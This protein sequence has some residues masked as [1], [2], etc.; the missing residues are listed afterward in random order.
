MS[1]PPP[2]PAVTTAA[3]DEPPAVKTPQPAEAVN[4]T[5]AK[6]GVAM[7]EG[8]KHQEFRPGCGA[9]I[10]STEL[11][12]RPPRPLEGPPYMPVIVRSDKV[13]GVVDAAK[14]LQTKFKSQCLCIFPGQGWTINDLWDANDIHLETASFCGE[15]LTFIS[16]DTYYA[17]QQFAK[18]WMR[19]YPDRLQLVGSDMAE[20][21]NPKD[22]FAIVEKIFT[23]GEPISF[24]RTFLWHVAHMMRHM[25]KAMSNANQAALTADHVAQTSQSLPPVANMVDVDTIAAKNQAQDGPKDGAAR[26]KKNRKMLRSRRMLTKLIEPWFAGASLVPTHATQPAGLP[27]SGPHPTQQRVPSYTSHPGVSS[28]EPIGSFTRNTAGTPTMSPNMN[29]QALRMPKNKPRNFSSGSYNQSV[30]PQQWGEN[31]NR[32][33]SGGYPRHP[34]GGMPTSGSPQFMHPAMAP[35]QPTMM[36]PHMM[37][38]YNQSAPMVSGP[39]AN[40]YFTSG[41]APRGT[42]APP[43]GLTQPT[44]GGH[45]HPH[46]PHGGRGMPIGDLTNYVYYANNMGSQHVD[47]RAPVSRRAN[48]YN[49]TGTLYDP[50]NGTNPKFSDTSNHHG[51][52]FGQNNSQHQTERPP[53]KTSGTGNRPTQG[54]NITERAPTMP[55]NVGR[56]SGQNTRRISSEDDPAITGDLSSGCHEHWIGEHNETV[57]ELFMGDLPLDIQEEELENLF[58]QLAG[59]RPTNVVVKRTPPLH[60]TQPY[61]R[62]HAFVS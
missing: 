45:P 10:S 2:P 7:Q 3:T 39:M 6:T 42:L 27:Q 24:P 8:S 28:T 48:N 26:S 29:P 54:A 33:P 4:K 51:R 56:Y 37:P 57:T 21:Y 14:I 5:D 52:K 62:L 55:T 44:L 60:T 46:Q 25:L 9:A 43:P 41:T 20:L 23:K 49:N 12:T 50:Y 11:C 31:M 22:H 1:D 13:V 34:S 15:M 38:P 36:P 40:H 17:A 61:V 19:K 58:A 18:D 35:V 30:P 16:R 47:P 32:V 59:V 53:R